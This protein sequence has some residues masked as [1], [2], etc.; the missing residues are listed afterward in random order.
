[1]I[2]YRGAGLLWAARATCAMA[3]ASIVMEGEEDSTI[4]VSFVPTMKVW[5]WIAL[6]LR[7]V[8]DFLFA[9]QL[10]NGALATLP[11]TDESKEECAATSRNWNTRLE[12][13]PST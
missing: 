7:H 4:P 9:I 6:G 8:P 1:M 11:L 3:A 12:A 5:A 2:A 10:L 13:S